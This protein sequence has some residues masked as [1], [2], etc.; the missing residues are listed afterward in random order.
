MSNLDNDC[1]SG[2]KDDDPGD[3]EEDGEWFDAVSTPTLDVATE[4]RAHISVNAVRALGESAQEVV[5]T[6]IMDTPPPGREDHDASYRQLTKRTTVDPRYSDAYFEIYAVDIYAVDI[7]ASSAC[8][9]RSLPPPAGVESSDNDDDGGRLLPHLA[10][11]SD[12]ASNDDSPQ[13]SEIQATKK[14]KRKDPGR[15]DQ[16]KKKRKDPGRQDQGIT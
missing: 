6:T 5:I 8:S 11:G 16:G 2:N 9:E 4:N 3:D 14:K 7:G 1:V 13:P 15:Q 12:V 10:D